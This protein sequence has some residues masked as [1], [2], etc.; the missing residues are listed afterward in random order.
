VTYLDLSQKLF[1][2]LTPPKVY[3]LKKMDEA[4]TNY[5]G[6]SGKLEELARKGIIK[7]QI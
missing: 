6:I 3:S 2:S 4:F 5:K 1:S 7:V